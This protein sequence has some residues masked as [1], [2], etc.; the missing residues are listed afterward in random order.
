MVFAISQVD[1]RRAPRIRDEGTHATGT[2]DAGK[3][4]KRN[5]FR[6]SREWY[7]PGQVGRSPHDCC[8]I[9]VAT[10]TIEGPMR[11]LRRLPPL[12]ALACQQARAVAAQAPV[13]PAAGPAAPE[14]RGGTAS[15]RN[16]RSRRA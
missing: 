8:V 12:L 2:A 5:G 9:A 16:R 4:A 13:G 11:A 1:R 6:T 7:A 10:S 3:T 14:G 15:E